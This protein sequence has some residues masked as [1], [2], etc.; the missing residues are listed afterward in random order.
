MGMTL[1]LKY[2]NMGLYTISFF[3]FS[4]GFSTCLDVILYISGDEEASV[5]STLLIVGIQGVVLGLTGTALFYE[6][7]SRLGASAK[8]MLMCQLGVYVGCTCVMGIMGARLFAAD[9]PFWQY[10]CVM[11]PIALLIGS[12]QAFA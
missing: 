4:D 9:T 11:L 3:L 2:K 10:A 6:V 8:T 7:Q 5:P 1:M 12:L